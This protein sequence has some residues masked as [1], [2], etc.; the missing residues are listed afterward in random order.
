MPCGR[1]QCV[2][3]ELYTSASAAWAVRCHLTTTCMQS[4]GS[5]HSSSGVPVVPCDRTST[6]RS[7]LH[8]CE[9]SHCGPARALD[10]TSANVSFMSDDFVKTVGIACDTRSALSASLADGTS[11]GITGCTLKLSVKLASVLLK[12]KFLILPHLD[13][14][15]VVLGMHYLATHDARVHPRKLTVPLPSAKGTIVVKAAPQ[16]PMLPH[17]STTHVDVVSGAKLAR[18]IRHETKQH[19]DLPAALKT[20]FVTSEP[21][22]SLSCHSAWPTR[23]PSSHCS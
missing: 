12:H 9:H 20:T 18:I 23:Q 13:D 19:C 16:Q 8:N 7:H 2:C 22:S 14:M 5:C 3:S 11:V 4:A 17:M 6:Y 10:D 1:S 21:L 15:D